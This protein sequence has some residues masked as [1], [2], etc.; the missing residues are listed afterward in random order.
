MVTVSPTLKETYIV[1]N[2][3]LSGEL[4]SDIKHEYVNGIIYGMV[5]ASSNHVTICWNLSV[6][7]GS[8]LKGRKCQGFNSNM[9]LKTSNGKF[10]YPDIMIVCDEIIENDLYKESPVIIIEVLSKST[11]QKDKTE[12]KI[13]YLNIPTLEQYILIEQDFIDV[14]V[15]KKENDWR[16]DHYFLGDKIPLDLI[17]DFKMPI[18]DIY[19]QVVLV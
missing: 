8:F 10:R 9:K 15:F 12:K 1:E 6:G 3:Y 18:E 7:I 14:E 11:R 16:S 4:T 17:G 5:G 19:E 2:E 13:E